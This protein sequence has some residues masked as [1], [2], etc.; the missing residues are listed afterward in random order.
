MLGLIHLHSS[1][2][3]TPFLRFKRKFE[4]KATKKGFIRVVQLLGYVEAHS[5]TFRFFQERRL[6]SL[7]GGVLFR[8]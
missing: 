5:L 2:L 1:G 4:G 6:L 7:F 8:E 3:V